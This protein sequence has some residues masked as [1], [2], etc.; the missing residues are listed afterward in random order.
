MN[1]SEA[2]YVL[3]SKPRKEDFLA[4][5]LRIRKIDIFNP[6]IRVNPVN[7][8]ARKLQP[9]FPGYIFVRVDLDQTGFSMLQWM[10][11]AVGLVSFG[12]K[13]A[14]VSDDLIQAIRNRV[15]TINIAGGE[16]PN[17]LNPGEAIMVHSGP[18]AG[19]EAIFDSHVSGSARVRVLLELLSKQHVLLELPAG[20]IQRKVVGNRPYLQSIS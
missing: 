16:L 15:S 8:R 5:Q 13:A 7:P 20:Q 4:E 3:R 2:W 19:Y 9:Y 1:M 10:P 17:G 18:F 11:G 14:L 6:H 12:G